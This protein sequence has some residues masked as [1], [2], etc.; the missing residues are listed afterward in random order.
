MDY[1]CL[2]FL[3]CNIY[4]NYENVSRVKYVFF[5]WLRALSV[6][7]KDIYM[8]MYPNSRKN[9]RFKLTVVW[10]TIVNWASQ[11]FYTVHYTITWYWKIAPMMISRRLFYCYPIII[12]LLMICYGPLFPCNLCFLKPKPLRH[13][14]NLNIIRVFPLMLNF[15]L[16]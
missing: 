10:K 7:E 11:G 6:R 13:Q 2:V 1:I 3:T 14:L 12:I 8:I 9:T 16:K 15:N 4:E 5:C